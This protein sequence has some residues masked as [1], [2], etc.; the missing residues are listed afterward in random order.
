MFANVNGT[1]IYFDIEGSGYVPRGDRMESRPVLFAIHGGP[2]SDHS[3]FKPWL[4]PLAKEMQIVYMDQR[5]NGQSDRVD[6]AMCTFNQLT[7]DIEALRQY[8][9]FDKIH[10][11]GHSFG[12]MVAQVFATR[13]PES[14]EKLLLV[15]T[16]PSYEFY[17]AALEY[18][19]AVATEEQLSVIPEMFEGRVE[20]EQQLIRWWDICYPLYF[21]VQNEEVM[22]ETGNR[23][24]GCLE[25]ANYT[26]KHFMPS[27]DVRPK[28]PALQVPT[29]IV[30]G[31]YD[32]ITPVSQ[33]E[34]MHRLI[35]QSE[36]AV[37]EYSGHMPF[38]EEHPGFIRTLSCFIAGEVS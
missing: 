26:F 38:I 12:G 4:T 33:A 16:A 18:A 17:S 29:L 27:Y 8:L 1:R 19:S 37:F 22:R 14:L 25:I 2:G 15:N 9:G 36:L 28:L 34:E 20:N 10:L 32:W 35:P 3:D 23:P 31:R 30:A 21:H 11:L 13:Y 6:P 5:C 24:I 7:D